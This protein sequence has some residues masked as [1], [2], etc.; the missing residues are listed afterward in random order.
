MRKTVFKGRNVSFY[1]QVARNGRA[2][3]ERFVQTFFEEDER[4]A[5]RLIFRCALERA[6]RQHGKRWRHGG[7]GCSLLV[8][9]EREGGYKDNFL[10][11]LI[12]LT[13]CRLLPSW[14]SL[15]EITCT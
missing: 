4:C 9:A 13:V 10:S 8:A 3:G 11:G 1:F 15:I 6:Q 14:R 2:Y 5:A 12:A 7:G